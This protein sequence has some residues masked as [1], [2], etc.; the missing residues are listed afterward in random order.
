MKSLIHHLITPLSALLLL[1]GCGAKKDD[2][3]L[4]IGMELAYP[5]FEM[6]NAQSE[7]DGVSVRVAEALGKYLNRPIKIK[8][9]G[10]DGIILELQTGKIDLILS[11]MTKTAEREKSIAFSDPY[12]TNSLCTLVGKDSTITGPDDL[13]KPGV[14]IAVKGETTG[15]SYVEEFFKE[16]VTVRLDQASDCVL[17]VMQGKVD[18]FIYDQIS[19][20]NAWKTHP[21]ATKPIYTP[22][23]S[24]SWA[25]GLRQDDNALREQVNAFL[26][27]FKANKGFDALTERYMAAEKKAL[28]EQGVPFIFE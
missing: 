21:E 13:K 18:A 23:R 16:A 10:W 9:V 8:D 3:T 19:I 27:E 24:E 28:A 11:S 26:A 25:I 6:T 22:L 14:R 7:P 4:V 5:P 20:Y 1:A 15:E 2:N 17:Q 12:V